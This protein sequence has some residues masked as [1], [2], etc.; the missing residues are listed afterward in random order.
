MLDAPAATVDRAAVLAALPLPLIVVAP[1]GRLAS[2]N[3]AA[4]DF[5]A[6]S[7]ESLTLRRLDE[8]IPFDSPLLAL[9]E[10]VRTRQ[11]P[12]FD[13]DVSLQSARLG[14]RSVDVQ[15]A[16]LDERSGFVVVC[17]EPLAIAQRLSGRLQP[18]HAA[19]SVQALAAMLAHEVKNPL[20]G[21]RGAAQLL[22]QGA[23]A[24]DR[25]LARLIRD[26]TDR[27][28]ALIGRFEAFTDDRLSRARVNI[29]EV[30]NRVRAI[31]GAGFA[32][33]IAIEERYD[34]S[35]PPTFANRDQLIQVFL[36][37]IKNAAEAVAA[38]AERRIAI[39][40]AYRHGIW[41]DA[42]GGRERVHLPLEVTIADNGPGIRDDM[43]AI[44]FSPFVTTKTTGSG[45]GLALVAKIVGDHGGAIDFESDGRGTV[46]RVRLP[47]VQ[48]GQR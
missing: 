25:H 5:F 44:L 37:L 36:N 23:S 43:Q 26:E 16:P 1:D 12:V 27:I 45:L 32:R 10:Q 34:P 18:R 3:P 21:I 11:S 46:F 2:V 13:H 48:E 38:Q 6:A 8:L 39:G 17:L 30:L 42:G 33:G 14:T 24:E 47:V 7:A 31:A 20:A 4:E 28:V 15:A 19:R 22:E 41:L 29:H 9:I 35:L 40:T